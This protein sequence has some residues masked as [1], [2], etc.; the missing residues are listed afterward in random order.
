[1]NAAASKPATRRDRLWC[2][3]P[4][5]AGVLC[6]CLPYNTLAV[7][8]PNP[9]PRSEHARSAGYKCIKGQHLRVGLYSNS[10]LA[11]GYFA[12][13]NV[14]QRYEGL[15]V[16]LMQQLSIEVGFSYEIHDLGSPGNCRLGYSG[17]CPLSGECQVDSSGSCPKTGEWNDFFDH[18]VQKYDVVGPWWTQ[19]TLRQRS[20]LTDFLPS[21]VDNSL[22]LLTLKVLS[23]DDKMTWGKATNF[24][25]PIE[26]P[27]WALIFF[28]CVGTGIALVVFD[29]CC[30]DGVSSFRELLSKNNLRD[31]ESKV[32]A[33]TKQAIA[34]MLAGSAELGAG[35]TASK[36]TSGS[37]SLFILVVLAA[38]TGNTAAFLTVS[39][40]SSQLV[41]SSVEQLEA[42]SET[43][44]AFKSDGQVFNKVASRFDRIPL[45]DSSAIT[46][47]V[48]GQPDTVGIEDMRAD[49]PNCKALFKFN[50]Q[51]T[52]F[53]MDR[54]TCDVVRVGNKPLEPHAK[55]GALAIRRYSTWSEGNITRS[56]C[57][58]EG[59][60]VAMSHLLDTMYVD[61]LEL[62][63]FPEA[64]CDT[65]STSSTPAPLDTTSFYGIILLHCFIMIVVGP[66]CQLYDNHSRRRAEG[67]AREHLLEHL[68]AN[69]G[70]PNVQASDEVSDGDADAA[71]DG[72]RMGVAP[73]VYAPR[74][75][76]SVAAEGGSI[77][78]AVDPFASVQVRVPMPMPGGGAEAQGM[79]EA[80][81]HLQR[82]MMLLSSQQATAPTPGRGRA[83]SDN[84]TVL[85][86][87]PPLQ[88]PPRTLPPP[89]PRSSTGAGTRLAPYREEVD[90]P[91]LSPQP[92]AS[93]AKMPPVPE[94]ELEGHFHSVH[95]LSAVDLDSSDDGSEI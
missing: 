56:A 5:L 58:R 32:E 54:G 48:T 15:A 93:H 22:V 3:L 86:P 70:G 50:F 23:K 33:R 17:E 21:F 37:F 66:I 16:D 38:Y 24:M 69:T 73:A 82:A 88:P 45:L 92:P 14:T 62:F 60:T 39:A 74:R 65:A 53:K 90:T 41:V 55:G 94:Q 19:S 59:L 67:K 13:N 85:P 71:L 12:Y 44:C 28:T 9:F 63:Y 18:V 52:V 35:S 34:G 42:R 61:E 77:T 1:M 36:L 26:T 40:Q 76:S 79:S 49:P 83:T 89:P 68:D 7:R 51:A 57:I 47:R 80:Q 10:D 84:E 2:G 75:G 11:F 91:T 6:M 8:K 81:L 27:A 87:P 43:A 20:G 31:F 29:E 30:T 95:H 4:A 46:D 78:T 64:Q 25:D 72:L